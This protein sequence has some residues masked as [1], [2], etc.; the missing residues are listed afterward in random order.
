MHEVLES[1]DE[2]YLGIL[3]NS[4]QG[5]SPAPVDSIADATAKGV[6][7]RGNACYLQ[8][9]AYA[10]RNMHVPF[11]GHCHVLLLHLLH[12]PLQGHTA[13][14]TRLPSAV[15]V[16]KV[17]HSWCARHSALNQST[18][19]TFATPQITQ[20]YCW[21]LASNKLKPPSRRARS[22]L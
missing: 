1:A 4:L 5:G 10:C 13:R 6:V 21:S 8:E 19:F 12:G 3:I 11:R 18:D 16:C 14:N 22:F 15:P 17:S 9:N 7:P 2:I 20:P